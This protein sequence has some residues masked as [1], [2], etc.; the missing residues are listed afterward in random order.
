MTD[1]SAIE[2]SARAAR[3]ADLELQKRLSNMYAQ[4]VADV[5]TLEQNMARQINAAKAAGVDVKPTW[6]NQQS[7]YLALQSEY[8]RAL[9]GFGGDAFD[10]V[11]AVLPEETRQRLESTLDEVRSQSV[12]TIKPDYDSRTWSTINHHALQAANALLEH[13]MS[14]LRAI[15]ERDF[16]ETGLAQF[17]HA[18]NRGL[19]LG[20]N[21]LRI[22]RASSKAIANLSLGRAQLIARTEFHRAYREG[23]REQFSESRIIKQWVWR[24]ALDRRTCAVCW[25]MHGS[26]HPT[27][28]TLD[29]HPACRCVMV[30]VTDTP[31]AQ[32]MLRDLGTGQSRFDRLPADQQLRILGPSRF[33]LHQEGRLLSSM[34]TTRSSPLWGKHRTLE[35]LG[36]ARTVPRRPPS[37]APVSGGGTAPGGLPETVR[38]TLARRANT[39]GPGDEIWDS[40]RTI[41]NQ[42]GRK[43]DDVLAEAKRNLQKTLDSMALQ[44]RRSQTSTIRILEEGRFKSQFETNTS[45]GVM[46]HEERGKAEEGMFGYGGSLPAQQRPIY[47][48]GHHPTWKKDSADSYGEVVFTLKDGVR[49]R[50]TGVW[51]DSLWSTEKPSAITNISPG[52]YF[53][54]EQYDYQ[55][56]SMKGATIPKVGESGNPYVEFQFHGGLSID[57][58]AKITFT[59]NIGYTGAGKPT[60]EDLL[61]KRGFVPEEV[62]K[63]KVWVRPEPSP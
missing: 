35:P 36:R 10:L 60:M 3:N 57:D 61:R 56:G 5:T 37:G 15:F 59:G 40:Y 6:L 11:N 41:A 63:T 28:D 21:P 18:W 23:K 51:T 33:K 14:P 62:G 12:N 27:T 34:I 16:P 4:A 50:T 13:D 52:S 1:L 25:G 38:T 39:F 29:G 20:H 32:D 42:L 55:T 19:T 48:Y 47:G 8:Y 58:V 53:P 17:R 24:S 7:R 43:V 26:L 2:Q 22:A 49:E 9:S 31:L 46:S 44:T 45:A 30:P 54:R